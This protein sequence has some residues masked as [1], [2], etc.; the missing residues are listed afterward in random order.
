MP[1]VSIFAQSKVKDDHHFLFAKQHT[2]AQARDQPARAGGGA[3]VPTDL[4]GADGLIMVNTCPTIPWVQSDWVHPRGCCCVS[5]EGFCWP[6]GWQIATA[7]GR[8][9]AEHAVRCTL[10][11]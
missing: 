8:G 4:L 11:F 6:R 2:A 3:G 1:C 9:P 10:A 7:M 5:K